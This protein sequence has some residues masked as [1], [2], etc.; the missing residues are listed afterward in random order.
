[1]NVEVEL[2]QPGWTVFTN[3]GQELGTVVGVESGAIRVKTHGLLSH[4]LLVPL[5]SVQEVETGRVEL[6][7]T[8]KEAEANRA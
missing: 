7:M 4:E 5:S 3:D 6:S 1:M 2:V 8:K